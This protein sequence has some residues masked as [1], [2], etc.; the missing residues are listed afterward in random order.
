[1]LRQRPKNKSY[2][3]SSLFCWF[4]IPSCRT[5]CKVG[6]EEGCKWVIWCSIYSILFLM[7]T[8]ILRNEKICNCIE[9]ELEMKKTWSDPA[10]AVTGEGGWWMKVNGWFRSG[11]CLQIS[12]HTSSAQK[13]IL[14][15]SDDFCNCTQKLGWYISCKCKIKKSFLL[16]VTV[17]EPWDAWLIPKSINV[18]HFING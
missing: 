6:N 14:N 11:G 16:F 10:T 4:L 8:G 1:M 18:V 3:L 7:H 17:I 12:L 5:D 9:L 15:L 2:Y 13:N